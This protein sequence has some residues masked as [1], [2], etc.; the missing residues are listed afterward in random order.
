LKQFGA[1]EDVLVYDDSFGE[2]KHFP[3]WSKVEDKNIEDAYNGAMEVEQGDK[4]ALSVGD[5]SNTEEIEV[6]DDEKPYTEDDKKEGEG[7]F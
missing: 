5:A 4:Q 3:C 1:Q 6:K 7:L 2:E